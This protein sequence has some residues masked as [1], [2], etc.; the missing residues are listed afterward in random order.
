[1]KPVSCSIYLFFGLTFNRAAHLANKLRVDLALIHKER[2]VANEVSRMILIGSVTDKVAIIIDDIADTCGTLTAAAEV[3]VQNGAK[4]C[5]GMVIH[6]FL[7]GPA[8]QRVAESALSRLVVA[9]TLPLSPKAQ[10]CSKIE[11]IDVS[12]VF[13]E[14]IRR[15][16]NSES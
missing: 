8:I 14:A 2:V 13:A 1:M 16:H 4:D 10:A 6:G 5:L 7:S 9:N 11:S 15:T 3:L 12:G